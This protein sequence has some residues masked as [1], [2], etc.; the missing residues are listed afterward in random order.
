MGA[1]VIP[2]MPKT[3]RKLVFMNGQLVGEIEIP[4]RPKP[5]YQLSARLILDANGRIKPR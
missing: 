3:E 1:G 5:L 4:V 2:T